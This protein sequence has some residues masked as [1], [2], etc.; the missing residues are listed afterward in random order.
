MSRID[1]VSEIINDW[2]PI[3]LFPYAPSD[4]YSC[5]V[6]LINDFLD[7]FEHG[8][9]LDLG[10]EIFQVFTKSFGD[11]FERD[12]DECNAIADKIIKLI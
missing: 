8:V 12:Q 10:Y 9:K 7:K 5:E 11:V 2:D 4:E 1:I 6:A 3:E